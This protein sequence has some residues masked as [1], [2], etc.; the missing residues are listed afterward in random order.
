MI[1][2]VGLTLTSLALSTRAA[3][4]AEC[5]L[6]GALIN[7]YDRNA[8][9]FMSGIDERDCSSVTRST[10]QKGPGLTQDVV[11]HQKCSH[12]APPQSLDLL[13]VLISGKKKCYPVR[14]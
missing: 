13:M 10:A 2:S 12:V 9:R 1:P 4:P 8:N 3:E 14:A 5:L 7:V 6:L 11:G